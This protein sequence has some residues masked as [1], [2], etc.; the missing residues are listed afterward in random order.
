MFRDAARIGQII[1]AAG[2]GPAVLEEA[3]SWFDQAAAIRLCNVNLASLAGS[4]LSH[5]AIEARK[6][7]STR[8]AQRIRGVAQD[9]RD[10]VSVEDAVTRATSGTL[11][12][13]G[14]AI[15]AAR[16]ACEPVT[17]QAI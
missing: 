9:L 8:D 11:V 2:T 10:A 1:G 5:F 3:L 17:E 4:P 13:A 6:A 14:I 16:H 15:D 12:L 7:L